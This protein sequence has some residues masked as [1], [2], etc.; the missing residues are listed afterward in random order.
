MTEQ[1]M[2]SLVLP[3]VVTR[4]EIE[5]FC[6]ATDDENKIH[7]GAR[8]IVPGF[9]ID[10]RMK[11][12]LDELIQGTYSVQTNSFRDKLFFDVP[13]ELEF[14]KASEEN[15]V[16]KIESRIYQKGNY[17][18]EKPP[19]KGVITYSTILPEK[20]DEE[21]EKRFEVHNLPLDCEITPEMLD[22]VRSTIGASNNDWVATAV[23][24]SSSALWHDFRGFI[25]DRT[26]L[27]SSHEILTYASVLAEPKFLRII[28]K[29]GPERQGLYTV[30]ARGVDD[31]AEAVFDGKFVIAFDKE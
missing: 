10:F 21:W 5:K 25:G 12:H 11:R 4:S 23:G 20:P 24:K 3:F 27:Y 7:K 9:L 22:G 16:V 26:P 31:E 6:E 30:F 18:I 17:S 28:T 14:Q 15:G 8:P 1:I 19:V 2:E 29:K 13:Y